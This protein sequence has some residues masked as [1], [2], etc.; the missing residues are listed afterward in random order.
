M[1]CRRVHWGQECGHQARWIVRAGSRTT[2]QMLSC[3]ACLNAVC[4]AMTKA[5]G[6]QSA[7]ALTVIMLEENT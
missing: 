3:G 1:K 2:D 7:V 4:R 6:R 5:E